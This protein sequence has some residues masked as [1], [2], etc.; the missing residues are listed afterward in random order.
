MGFRL[1]IETD[2]L[3][4]DE[5]HVLAMQFQVAHQLVRRVGKETLQAT[6]KRI[7]IAATH[8]T[9]KLNDLK[10]CLH[11]VRIGI[12]RQQELHKTLFHLAVGKTETV[13]A[14]FTVISFYRQVAALVNDRYRVSRR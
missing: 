6:E 13:D 12:E 3:V 7:V 11:L 2:Q 1:Y 10:R 5:Q 4:D 8:F 9:N 14:K